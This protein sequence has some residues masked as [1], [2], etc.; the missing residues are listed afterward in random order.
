M[1]KHGYRLHRPDRF[2][3]VGRYVAGVNMYVEDVDLALN[4]VDHQPKIMNPQ[5]A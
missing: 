3:S 4:S 2:D 1:L 5:I